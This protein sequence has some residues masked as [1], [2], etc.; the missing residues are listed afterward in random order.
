MKMK[1][2]TKTQL[3]LELWQEARTRFNIQNNITE[4]D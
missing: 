1:M 3:F 2:K 4:K